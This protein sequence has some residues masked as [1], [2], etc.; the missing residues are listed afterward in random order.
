MSKK[1]LPIL[2]LLPFIFSLLF[3]IASNF[4]F[5]RIDGDL[6]DIVWSYRNHEGFAL[7]DGKIEQK[8]LSK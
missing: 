3:F 6:A 1:T 2:L 4:L 7:K 8:Y 5:T